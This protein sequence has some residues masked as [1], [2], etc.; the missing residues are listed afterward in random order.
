MLNIIYILYRGMSTLK[1]AYNK[2]ILVVYTS[3]VTS[4][5]GL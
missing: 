5:N 2:F 1:P 3:T 4:D